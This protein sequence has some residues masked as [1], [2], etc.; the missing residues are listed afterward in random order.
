M[1]NEELGAL[2]R[3]SNMSDELFNDALYYRELANESDDFY[4]QW[5]YRRSSIISFCASAEA[6]INCI[7]KDNLN[8]KKELLNDDE[9]KLLNF[10]EDYNSKMPYGFNNVRNKLY[11]FI[12]KAINGANINWNTDRK[13]GFED[14]IELSNMRNTV[15]HYAVKNSQEVHSERFIQLVEKAPDVIEELFKIYYLMGSTLNIPKWYKTRHPRII[16]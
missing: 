4:I 6:W 7:I 15:I 14:Y 3:I 8:K 11:N 5:R 13:K 10:I 12:P 1:S 2:I 9:Q 16:K